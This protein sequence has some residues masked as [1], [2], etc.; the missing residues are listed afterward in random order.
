MKKILI[1][2]VIVVS[3]ISCKAVRVT[4]DYAI[5][6]DFNQ[7]RTYAY[8]KKGIDEVEVSD[9]DK[10]RILKALDTELQAR[11]YAK[12]NNPD[13]IVSFFTDAQERVDVFN[14]VGFGWGGWGWGGYGM[15]MGMG[16]GNNV[17]VTTE[18]VLFIDFID[19]RN[20]ELIWQGVGR[21]ALKSRPEE[22]VER[23]NEMVRE[24]LSQYPP[25]PRK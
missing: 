12:S 14:N 10:K 13:L 18:G 22:K 2:T 1:L 4:Q 5:G 11:G 24:I 20:K 23:T 8:F 16:M 15:G 25:Q 19:A 7:Y 17:S 6:T 21:A 3:L 9:L